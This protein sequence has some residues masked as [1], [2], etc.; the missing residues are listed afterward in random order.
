MTKLIILILVQI[1]KVAI[2]FTA[3]IISKVTLINE[4]P[5]WSRTD[6]Q[7]QRGQAHSF[8]L[9][10]WLQQHNCQKLHSKNYCQTLD[11]KNCNKNDSASLGQG[12]DLLEHNPQEKRLWQMLKGGWSCP[13]HRPPPPRIWGW[14]M[15]NYGIRTSEVKYNIAKGREKGKA[16]F[17][18]ASLPDPVA[19]FSSV[20]GWI[21]LT[22]F[23]VSFW[24]SH[25]SLPGADLSNSS[26]VQ[27]FRQISWGQWYC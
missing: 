7:C 19:T 15:H 6:L 22:S 14:R 12:R 18:V 24:I 13:H 25:N 11:T 27:V 10:L 20:I 9:P 26:A 8:C 1:I 4:W 3:I 23:G 17:L 5:K 21:Q 16:Y 2:K